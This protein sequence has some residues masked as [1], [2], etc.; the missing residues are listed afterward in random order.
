MEE[1]K[2]KSTFFKVV[3]LSKMLD[4]L[5]AIKRWV[6]QGDGDQMLDELISSEI[7]ISFIV[8]E[9]KMYNSG[10]SIS[11]AKPRSLI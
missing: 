5:I 7:V 11:W 6:R 1:P 3:P 2:A 10:L 4:E 8:R 9:I